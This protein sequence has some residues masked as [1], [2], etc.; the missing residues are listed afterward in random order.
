MS[1]RRLLFSPTYR[2][3]YQKR[4]L[5]T[6]PS[7]CIDQSHISSE[8]GVAEQ[9]PETSQEYL[10]NRS[11][12]SKAMQSYLKRAT[13]YTEFMEKEKHN[14][15]VGRRHLA[16]MMGADPETFTQKD[17]DEAVA[18]LMPSGLFDKKARPY[19][20]DPKEVFPPKKDAEFDTSGR[21][22]HFLFYTGKPFFYEILHNANLFIRNLNKM[23]DEDSR[24]K[25]GSKH[26]SPENGSESSSSRELV[27]SNTEWMSQNKLEVIVCETLTSD[28]YKQFI[29]VMTRLVEHP[30][31]YLK[32]EFIF[33]YR[34]TKMIKTMNFD[35]DT[36]QVNDNG[37][38]F[39]TTLNCPRKNARADVTVFYPGTGKI[40]INERAYDEF[41]TDVNDRQQILF[42]LL[43]TDMLNKVDIEANVRDG[44]L[45]GQAGA[46]RWGTSWGLRNFVSNEM[47][48][49]MR[50]AGLLTRDFRHR[51]R[52]KPGQKGARRK[53]T[54][55]KR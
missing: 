16:N 2:V 6:T 41:F 55:K 38:K 50:I 35:P 51:E 34:Q 30:Y 43:F 31:A 32:Q 18:Y 22:Y 19:M 42:P 12:V 47:L 11:K 52:K 54:W 21:P 10:F 24:K 26:S 49:R 20:K 36:P 9:I 46:V 15:E 48:D 33:T 28:E 23:L 17:I 40:L 1:L 5:S 44:G 3:S 14:F 13:E 27:L 8:E 45:S 39:V 4:H 25:G 29:N 7:L 37:V 53:F